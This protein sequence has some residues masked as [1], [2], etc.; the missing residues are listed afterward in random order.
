M[1][2]SIPDLI[3]DM[4]KQASET[5]LMSLKLISFI[6]EK[7]GVLLESKESE[8]IS[9]RFISP[10]G[11]IQALKLLKALDIGIPADYLEL[12]KFQDPLPQ[13]FRMI[14]KLLELE[15]ID[16]AWL[17][18][19]RKYPEVQEEIP[20][21]NMIL[22]RNKNLDIECFPSNQSE[23]TQNITAVAGCANLILAINEAGCLSVLENESGRVLH[24]LQVFPEDPIRPESLQYSMTAPSATLTA[25]GV[26][27]IAI[28]K[29][30]VIPKP[31]VD[32]VAEAEETEK[33][34]KAKAAAAKKGPPA[35]GKGPA[36]TPEVETDKT[37]PSPTHR[38]TVALIDL[39]S[40]QTSSVQCNHV[41]S[42]D[43]DLL[44]SQASSELSGDGRLLVVSHGT[45][46]A[47]FKFPPVDSAVELFGSKM[48][49]IM[50]GDLDSIDDGAE[51]KS[52]PTRGDSQVTELQSQW[53]IPEEIFKQA[54]PIEKSQL[55]TLVAAPPTDS[56]SARD[57]S[58][59]QVP[60]P[61]VRSAHLFAFGSEFNWEDQ[62]A[63]SAPAAA[64]APGASS[65]YAKMTSF[66]DNRAV[67]H[68]GLVVFLE[69]FHRWF[70]FGL[71]TAPPPPPPAPPISPRVDLKKD[72][73]AP[74]AP[75]PLVDPLPEDPSK[76]VWVI[77]LLRQF[78]LSSSVTTVEFDEKR[79]LLVIGQSDGLV[80]LWDLKAM[81]LI[82]LVTR[83]HSP[84]TSLCLTKGVSA[85]F[86]VSGDADGVLCFHKLHVAVSL[87]SDLIASSPSAAS[88]PVISAELV[89]FRLD[90]TRES[91]VRVWAMEGGVSVVI[92]QV[93][94]GR[95][96]AYDADGAELLGRLSLTSGVLGLRM[97]YTLALRQDCTLVAPPPSLPT[98]TEALQQPS[99][100]PP[101]V[102]KKSR[103]QVWSDR[104]AIAGACSTGFCAYFFRPNLK[105]VLSSF[106]LAKL[107]SFFPGISSLCKHSASKAGKGKE[108]SPLVLY[109]TLQPSQRMEPNLKPSQVAH[110]RESRGGD[111]E[112]SQGKL[113]RAGSRP[114]PF[115]SSN[116]NLL[117]T[118]R[119][120]ELEK[121]YRGL[122]A[123]P[124][125]L[126]P[127]LADYSASR[128]ISPK[129]E[130]ERSIKASQNE[131]I[132][133][134][135]TVANSFKQLS[136]LL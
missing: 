103:S 27:R 51:M 33:E 26:C 9:R 105:S 122:D 91:I 67:Y 1:A 73:A 7:Y 109:K 59:S 95:L 88:H 113:S 8:L 70:I 42:F 46:V 98:I 115:N 135:M 50:E 18:I 62:P 100:P 112:K 107:L 2:T 34:K 134:K 96:V 79:S 121:S 99:A 47:Y 43:I 133:R 29:T 125:P 12:D 28:F 84:V 127:S 132:N 30:K 78:P 41:H 52:P 71:R 58:T 61:R 3:E 10:S 74:V 48:G 35:K 69:E 56:L 130:F 136:H 80:S 24:T 117:T 72:K 118:E 75:P 123:A 25:L 64:S 68:N 102:E 4:T 82:S 16:R 19:L 120:K 36:V 5:G 126:L 45:A 81:M 65:N 90:F 131:R 22:R 92:V 38:C 32:P 116:S 85:H 21:R 31:P 63:P 49:K 15:I 129:T 87:T 128:F 66:R 20:G 108:L 44:S 83:H 11:S 97:E 17:E 111:E 110:L 101:V 93:S 77:D 106:N 119:L 6:F 89:D 39:L 124:P 54:S 40:L 37:K 57:P 55:A 76:R 14:S 86:L 104:T 94:S 60:V 23:R 114:S 53:V 13:P